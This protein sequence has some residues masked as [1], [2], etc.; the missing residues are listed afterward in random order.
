[1]WLGRE[2][3]IDWIYLEGKGSPGKEPGGGHSRTHRLKQWQGRALLGLVCFWWAL[4]DGDPMGH[5]AAKLYAKEIQRDTTQTF[6]NVL[7]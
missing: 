1:M 4:Q 3:H 5:R 2:K 6:H 7:D